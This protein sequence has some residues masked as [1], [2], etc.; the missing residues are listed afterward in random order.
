V[1]SEFLPIVEAVDRAKMSPKTFYNWISAGRLGREEGLRR[2]GRRVLI[3]WAVFEAQVLRGADGI[4]E[5]R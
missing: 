5:S 1:E 3:E 2:W 4:A